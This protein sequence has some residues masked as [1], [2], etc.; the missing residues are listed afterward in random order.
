[1]APG[2]EYP[3]AQHG[4][5]RAPHQYPQV[6]RVDVNANSRITMSPLRKVDSHCGLLLVERRFLIREYVMS[7]R[8]MT[9]PLMYFG[10]VPKTLRVI[11]TAVLK[12]RFVPRNFHIRHCTVVSRIDVCLALKAPQLPSRRRGR[13]ICA[14]TANQGGI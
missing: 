3:R 11:S 7:A 4:F 5:R 12:P 2:G 13:P 14:G 8:T 6:V 1:M 10:R 9:S